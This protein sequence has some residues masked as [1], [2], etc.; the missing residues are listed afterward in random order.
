MPRYLIPLLLIFIAANAFCAGQTSANFL[1]IPIGAK[2]SAMGE[3]GAAESGIN[4]M[5]WNPAG[6]ATIETPEFSF[7][8]AS[9]FEG[10]YLQNAACALKIGNGVLGVS[11][12]YLSMSAITKYDNTGAQQDI[13]TPFDNSVSATYAWDISATPEKTC[14]GLTLKYINSHIVDSDNAS[15]V[16]MDAGI[17]FDTIFEDMRFGVV[18]QNLG[19]PMKFNSEAFSLPLNIKAGFN[20]LVT[21]GLSLSAD[22][23]KTIDT[24]AVLNGGAEYLCQ[25]GEETGLA[26]RGG[27]KSNNVELGGSAGVTMGVGFIFGVLTLDYAYVPYGDLGD[28]NR[29]SLGY[30]F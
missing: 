26:F 16:A 30:K 9:L 19:R 1:N 12:N 11:F 6:L 22:V 24:D 25:I 3:T 5:Y 29:I 17:Y 18:F 21:D 20:Y 13:F 23:N 7:G 10:I 2:N 15:T 28:T 8:N 4:A 27:Y 14:V